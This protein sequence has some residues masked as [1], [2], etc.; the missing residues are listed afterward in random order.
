VGFGLFAKRDGAP[1]IPLMPCAGVID[2]SSAGRAIG[3][4]HAFRSH[5]TVPSVTAVEIGFFR[6]LAV[7]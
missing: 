6:R 4:I 2:P 5:C 1:A 7:A 3:M